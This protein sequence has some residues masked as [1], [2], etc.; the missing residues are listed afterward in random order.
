MIL[1]DIETEKK[2]KE[3]GQKGEKI[4]L[5]YL[6]KNKKILNI[7]NIYNWCFGINQDD[8]KGYDFSYTTND[9]KEFFVEVKTT[10]KTLK[11]NIVFEMSKKEFSVMNEN[12]NKYF[13]YFISDVN[14]EKS[15]TIK[16]ISSIEIGNGIPSNYTFNLKK[17]NNKNT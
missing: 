3:I 2:K 9:D 15:I 11:D 14:N 5:D 8:S 4:V 6:E 12:R 13:I 16:R 7:K 10:I 1:L 17:I